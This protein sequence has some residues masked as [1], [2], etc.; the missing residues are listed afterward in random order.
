MA[1]LHKEN[2][3]GRDGYRLRF[4]DH[5]QRQRALWLG[6]VSRRTADTILRHIAELVRAKNAG[7]NPETDSVKWSETVDGRL[8]ERLAAFGVVLPN[9]RRPRTDEQRLLGP[10]IDRYIEER[11]DAK[12]STITN[13]RHA[14]QWLVAFFDDKKPLVDITPA[15]CD[16]WQ[17]F[18]NEGDKLAPSTIEKIL[19]RAK[20]MFRHAVRDRLFAENPFIDLKIGASVNRT[21]DAFISPELA[22]TVISKCPDNDWKVIFPLARYTGLRTPREVLTLKWSDIDWTERKIRIDSPK[23]GAAMLP[24]VRRTPPSPAGR[25]SCQWWMLRMGRQQVPEFTKEPSNGTDSNS[26]SFRP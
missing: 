21:R 2:D 22:K 1:S 19:K 10:F 18:L 26:R 9:T 23:N 8:R 17:R 25:R 15:D 11:T 6:K 7:V 3:R 14:R 20:T 13:Y 4:R 5:N 16:R 12:P 24:V